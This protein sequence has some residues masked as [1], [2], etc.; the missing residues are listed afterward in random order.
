LPVSQRGF[1]L[2]EILIVVA[3]VAVAGYLLMQYVGSTVTTVE[4][5]QKDRP[6]EPSQLKALRPCC[7]TA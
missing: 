5:L 1:G 7:K 4:R 3:V 6:I 2:I